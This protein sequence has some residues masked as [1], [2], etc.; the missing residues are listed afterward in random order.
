MRMKIQH[1][2]ADP[3]ARCQQEPLDERTVELQGGVAETV[4]VTIERDPLEVESPALAGLASTVAT[5]PGSESRPPMA[6]HPPVGAKPLSPKLY[7][8]SNRV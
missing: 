6:A 5:V 4:T 1:R 2:T 3:P 8:A 7:L